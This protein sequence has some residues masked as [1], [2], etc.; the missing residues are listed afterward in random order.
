MIFKNISEN[1][2]TF[3]LQILEVANWVK[4]IGNYIKDTITPT[5]PNGYK[6]TSI[7]WS[8]FS[9]RNLK[10]TVK[11][12]LHSWDPKRSYKTPKASFDG[13]DRDMAKFLL[14]I[15]EDAVGK[16]ERWL[17]WKKA[18]RGILS[19]SWETCTCKGSWFEYTRIRFE[20][21]K[22][23]QSSHLK[24]LALPRKRK[25]GI[26][27]PLFAPPKIK[28][29]GFVDTCSSMTEYHVSPRLQYCHNPRLC[30]CKQYRIDS[31]TLH[32]KN[33]EASQHVANGEA[34]VRYWRSLSR[35]WFA[36][37]HVNFLEY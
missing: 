35:R 8:F 21:N 11:K 29:V 36:N 30:I 5:S 15:F 19:H 1:S 16:I 23:Q 13:K 22:M 31:V 14:C 9:S 34:F 12:L 32:C 24:Q 10:K 17:V 6:K 26:S 3:I 25:S 20:E 37:H 33:D 2:L 27:W 18:Q 7:K 4:N 28:K